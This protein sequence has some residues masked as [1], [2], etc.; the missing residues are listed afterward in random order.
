MRE[1]KSTVKVKVKVKGWDGPRESYQLGY[2]Q[3]LSAFLFIPTSHRV[4][5]ITG[6]QCSTFEE[7]PK[8]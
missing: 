6:S 4:P 1:G 8:K 7:I 5:K 3:A 2:N